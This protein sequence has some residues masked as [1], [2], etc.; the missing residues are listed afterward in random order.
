MR[1]RGMQIIASFIVLILSLA[2]FVSTAFANGVIHE[3]GTVKILEDHPEA[4]TL[5]FT[6]GVNGWLNYGEGTCAIKCR[7][8]SHL[9]GYVG[10]YGD[11]PGTKRGGMYIQTENP[12][13]S[14]Q[15]CFNTH[16]MD[17]PT[18][19]RW[20]G[21]EW[22]AQPSDIGDEVICT[23]GSGEGVY[24]LMAVVHVGSGGGQTQI[25]PPSLDLDSGPF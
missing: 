7:I 8:S 18:I 12:E 10:D 23:N 2:L 14:Y 17:N 6:G 1:K 25:D 11:L 16:N 22:V 9:P 15:V 24:L 4:G 5:S 3:N 19:Y 13:G 20:N 21:D